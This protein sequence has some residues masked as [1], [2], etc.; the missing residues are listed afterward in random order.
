MIIF[1]VP[2]QDIFTMMGEG[3]STFYY[4][5]SENVTMYVP[6]ESHVLRAIHRRED[7]DVPQDEDVDV[8]NDLHKQFVLWR[9]TNLADAKRVLKVTIP[10]PKVNVNVED[11]DE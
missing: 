7:A 10:V 5:D 6:R 4:I 11:S 3:L 1:D 9:N 8:S 2:E